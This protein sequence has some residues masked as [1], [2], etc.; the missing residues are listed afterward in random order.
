VDNF[1]AH[2]AAG[3]TLDYSLRLRRKSSVGVQVDVEKAIAVAVW[4]RPS[5]LPC[6]E[7]HRCC[8]VEK[9]IAVAVEKAIAVAV[10]K[11][12]AV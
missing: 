8:R 9:A 11:A 1:E 10:E 6:G 4:R 12:I 3:W 2:T 5:L 7:G